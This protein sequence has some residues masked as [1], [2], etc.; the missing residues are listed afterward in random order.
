MVER[1]SVPRPS[2]G[3]IGDIQFS[4]IDFIVTKTRQRKDDNG[5]AKRQKFKLKRL[6]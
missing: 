4:S 6:S 5:L 3:V 2:P 1:E